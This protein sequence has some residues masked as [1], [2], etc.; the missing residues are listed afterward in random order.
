M[1]AFWAWH[2]SHNRRERF[3]SKE[4]GRYA[5]FCP[6]KTWGRPSLSDQRYRWSLATYPVSTRATMATPVWSCSGRGLPSRNSH[7]SLWWSLTP[8]F[9]PYRP[10]S[11]RSTLCGTIS[12]IS[13]G[14]CYP[15][16]CSVEPGRSSALLRMTRPPGRPLYFV[17][18]TAMKHIGTRGLLFHAGRQNQSPNRGPCLP[19][20]RRAHCPLGEPIGTPHRGLPG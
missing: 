7:L 2:I 6:R 4:A 10:E 16:P 18:D 9:H 5:G 3:G 11:R 17:K 14:G 8:P 1:P 19:Q 13:P 12:R 20:R 15:P